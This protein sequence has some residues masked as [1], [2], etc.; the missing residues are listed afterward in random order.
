MKLEDELGSE[1]AA[2][3]ANT[4]KSRG[5]PVLACLP[6]SSAAAGGIRKGDLVVEVNGVTIDGP[7]SYVLARKLDSDAMHVK[8]IRDE[9][10]LTFTLR[11]ESSTIPPVN[12]RGTLVS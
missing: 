7:E 1:L 12:A 9:R 2:F 4:P 6:G 10:V 5:L 11:L 8:L 3:L